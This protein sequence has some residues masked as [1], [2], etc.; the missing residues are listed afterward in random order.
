MLGHVFDHFDPQ[1]R[2]NL[3]TPTSWVDTLPE[4]QSPPD[5]QTNPLIN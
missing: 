3:G 1:L 2:V 4:P 5:Q